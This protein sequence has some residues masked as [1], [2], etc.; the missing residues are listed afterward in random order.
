MYTY[1]HETTPLTQMT[2]ALGCVGVYAKTD[3]KKR[4]K[5][6]FFLQMTIFDPFLGN[7]PLRP[8][9][10]EK[11]NISPNLKTIYNIS[12]NFTHYYVAFLKS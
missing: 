7:E 10:C 1:N 6:L 11:Y 8:R 5:D 9:K 4:H 2:I 3:K 12:K